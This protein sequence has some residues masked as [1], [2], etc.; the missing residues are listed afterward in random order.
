MRG[1][2]LATLSGECCYDVFL[3]E[4]KDTMGD[5]ITDP[6]SSWAHKATVISLQT[7]EDTAGTAAV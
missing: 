7:S 4:K 6:T 3:A 1:E 2:P 5:H